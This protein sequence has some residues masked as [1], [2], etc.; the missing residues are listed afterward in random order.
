[1]LDEKY[2]KYEKGS[3][4]IYVMSEYDMIDVTSMS[5]PDPAWLLVDAAGH[6]HRWRG[7][8]QKADLPTLRLVI[9]HECTDDCPDECY[10]L[11]HYECRQ[12]GERV[13]PRTIPSPCQRFVPGLR[14]S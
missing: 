1:M 4:I 5:E 6:E 9:D 7:D 13:E 2:E 3:E 10:P 14:R 8:W 12:C 11:S